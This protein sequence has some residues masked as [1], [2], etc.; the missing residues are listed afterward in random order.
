MWHSR[1]VQDAARQGKLWSCHV[2]GPFLRAHGSSSSCLRFLI[3]VAFRFLLWLLLGP[4]RSSFTCPLGPTT[5]SG[6][7]KAT[8]SARHP[9]RTEALRSALKLSL[10]LFPR[11]RA[12]RCLVWRHGRGAPGAGRGEHGESGIRMDAGSIRTERRQVA[13]KRKREGHSSSET[14][15]SFWS[16]SMS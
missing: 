14:R 2:A 3:D 16:A 6:W 9:S 12:G 15:A 8:P 11:K 4:L 5:P 13:E 7:V 1:A 10:S